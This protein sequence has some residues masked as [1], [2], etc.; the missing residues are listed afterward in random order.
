MEFFNPRKMCKEMEDYEIDHKARQIYYFNRLLYKLATRF[1]YSGLPETVRPEMMEM[2]L[3]LNGTVGVAYSNASKGIVSYV[4]HY[5]DNLDA[6][7]IGS[8]YAGANSIDSFDNE[9][10]E[11]VVVGINNIARLPEWYFLERYAKMLSSVDESLYIQLLASR[12]TPVIEVEDDNEKAQYEKAQKQ[13]EKGKP[14]VFVRPKR[15]SNITGE[16]P[17][18]TNVL[19]PNNS[20]IIETLDNLNSMHDDLMKRFFLEAGINISS[21]DKKAQLTVSEVD[22]YEDYSLINIV[23]AFECRK[24]MIEEVNTMFDLQASVELAE[25]YAEVYDRYF[26]KSEEPAVGDSVGDSEDGKAGESDEN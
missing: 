5:G 1:K 11:T 20:G 2:Q 26:D 15:L 25:P 6:Y 10:G 13:R 17:S 14:A 16:H 4:G 3:L 19:Q 18:A 23:D 22:S 21:K 8:R 7:G 24:K 12:D 9:I